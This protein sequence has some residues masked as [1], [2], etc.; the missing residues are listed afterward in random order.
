MTGDDQ[1]LE[2]ALRSVGDDYLRNNPADL[3]RARAK[4]DRLKRRRQ[5]RAGATTVLAT[6][7]A[8]AVAVYAWP[9]AEVADRP[10]PAGRVELP[11]GSIEIPVG[12]EP[13]EIA[14]GDDALWVSN[15]GD[16]TVSRLDPVTNEEVLTVNLSGAPGDLA[17]GGRGE[18]WAAIPELGEIHRIDPVT[19]ARTP[20]MRIPAVAPPGAALDLAIDEYLWVSVVGSELIQIDPYSGEIVQRIDDF[21]PVNVAARGAGVFVLEDDGTVRGVDPKTGEPNGFELSF[22]VSDRGDIH[23]YD[24][25]VWIAEG[26]GSKLFS[27]DVAT[28]SETIAEYSFRGEYMEMALVPQ[29]I[30]VL[31]DVGEGVGVVSLIDPATGETTEVAELEGGPRDLVRGAGDF[32]VSLSEDDAVVRIPALP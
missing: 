29:G 28:A 17:V 25:R 5:M 9:G 6:A 10:K 13:I 26:D 2:E 1:R 23:Y 3:H 15:T 22:D 31:S 7:A 8:V 4:V 12:D 20:D 14:V 21:S 27:A 30:L 18:V 32:W 16:A 19:N 11:A 24:D